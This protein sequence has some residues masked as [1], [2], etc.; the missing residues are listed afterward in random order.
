M[1][2]RGAREPV[3]VPRGGELVNIPATFWFCL[4]DDGLGVVRDDEHEAE[5]AGGQLGL[6]V[7]PTICFVIESAT[8]GGMTSWARR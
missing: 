2:V 1:A 5:S 6:L 3:H 7:N 8:K 4:L